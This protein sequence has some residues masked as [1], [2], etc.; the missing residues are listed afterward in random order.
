[1]F[2]NPLIKPLDAQEAL[3]QDSSPQLKYEITFNSSSM[4]DC[5]SFYSQIQMQQM[6]MSA[7]SMGNSWMTPVTPLLPPG[8]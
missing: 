6:M 8:N 5:R 2:V 1:V 7:M 3:A 4:S